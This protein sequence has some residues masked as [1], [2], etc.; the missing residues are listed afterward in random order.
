ML[1]FSVLSMY[2]LPVSCCFCVFICLV[3]WSWSV[4]SACL[5]HLWTVHHTII[6]AWPAP[7][8]ELEWF[9][10]QC[11][12]FQ[13]L[14]TDC[15]FSNYQCICRSASSKASVESTWTLWRSIWISSSSRSCSRRSFRAQVPVLMVQHLIIK[16]WQQLCCPG[17]PLLF[18][19][20]CAFMSSHSKCGY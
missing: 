8:I 11:F 1:V 4:K 17:K 13:C 18:M 3:S 20:C 10:F 12:G 9:H 19:S 2:L 15:W 16:C 6:S 14:V 5:L 7:G